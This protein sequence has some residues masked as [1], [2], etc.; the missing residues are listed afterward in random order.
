M[1][2]HIYIY[3]YMCVSPQGGGHPCRPGRKRPPGVVRG[4]PGPGGEGYPCGGPAPA[5]ASSRPLSKV[6][7]RACIRTGAHLTMTNGSSW[8]SSCSS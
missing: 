5:V 3:I 2:I 4:A 8:W 7:A 1:Y 6:V